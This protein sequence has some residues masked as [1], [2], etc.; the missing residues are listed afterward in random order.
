M[1]LKKKN[2]IARFPILVLKCLLIWP[3]DS[4]SYKQNLYLKTSII[5]YAAMSSIPIFSGVIYQVFCIFYMGIDSPNVLLELLV[6]LGD[7]MGYAVAYYCFLRHHQQIEKLINDFE[8]FAQYSTI[9]VIED[10][11][12]K[13]T[14]YTKYMLYCVLGSLTLTYIW[15][16]L[17]IK[18]C[19]AQRGSDYY[20][21]H[22]PCGMPVRNW[23][24]FDARQP[25][26]FWSIYVIEIMLGYHVSVFFSLATIFIIGF[27]MHIT[28]QLQ[29][30]ANKFEYIFDSNSPPDLVKKEFIYLN[31]YHSKILKYAERVFKVFDILI[32][33]YISLTSALMAVISYQI[34]NPDIDTQDRIKYAVL[35]SVWCALVY[36]ICY[37]GQIVQEES[38]K[39]G[40]SVYN[41][42]WYKHDGVAIKLKSNIVFTLGRSQKPLE[43]RT[44][45]FGSISLFQFMRRY[46]IPALFFSHEYVTHEAKKRARCVSCYSMYGKNGKIVDGKKKMASQV[47]TVFDECE[48]NPHFCKDCFDNNH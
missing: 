12:E 23:Y 19:I 35:L 34:I 36:L 47:I 13:S 29:C 48:G 44:Q 33:V 9:K 46:S 22:D 2:H 17:S 20:V 18:S 24:P 30:C 38:M 27:L 21:K 40:R 8:D 32:I 25:R 11:E 37:N 5:C 15:E 4:L 41:S 45:L 10:T 39:V 1:V 26:I 42:S 16:L 7:L 14:R 31:E 3:M 28:S 43:F 6:G